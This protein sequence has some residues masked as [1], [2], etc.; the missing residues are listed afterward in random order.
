VLKKLL[1]VVMVLLIAALTAVPAFAQDASADPSAP[2]GTDLL[3]PDCP[4]ITQDS[5]VW[6]IMAG[7]SQAVA[8]QC[9]VP[10]Q[11]AFSQ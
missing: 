10:P 8:D 7:M 11:P 5:T 3:V 9:G 6:A 2:F 4:T 1:A